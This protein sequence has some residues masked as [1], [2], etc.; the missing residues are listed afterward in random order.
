MSMGIGDGRKIDSRYKTLGMTGKGEDEFL[1]INE[2]EREAMLPGVGF[3]GG[4]AG[5][6]ED[7]IQAL[8]K[9]F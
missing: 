6:W 5:A 2:N 4:A 3:G 1:M 8:Q 9:I 7:V